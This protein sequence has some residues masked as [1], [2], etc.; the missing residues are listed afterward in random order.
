MVD[1]VGISDNIVKESRERTK[2]AMRNQGFDFPEGRVLVSLSPADLSKSGCFELPIALSVIS[3]TSPEKSSDERVLVLGGLKLSGETEF[4]DSAYAAVETAKTE[5]ISKVICPES[6]AEMIKDVDGISIGAADNLKDAVE[7]MQGR[8]PFVKNPEKKE[9][10]S[11][12]VKVT[13]P[14]KKAESLP[15]IKGLYKTARAI[16]VAVAGKHNLL[17]TGAP[18]CGKTMM[19]SELVPYLTPEITDEESKVTRRIRSVGG[20]DVP[21]KNR[22]IAPFRMPHQTSTIEG[23]YGGGRSLR[24]GEISL[25]NNGILFLDEAAE[26]R[27]SVLQMLRVPMENKFITLSRAGRSTVFPAKFQLMMAMNPC[28][29]GNFGCNGKTC[30]DSPNS[31]ETYWKKLGDELLSRVEIKD[32]LEKDIDDSR[33]FN[34]EESRK[35]IAAAY[36]IQRKRGIF[37][38]DLNDD[39]ISRY[40]GLDEKSKNFFVKTVKNSGLSARDSKNMLRTALTI[41]NMD[42]RENIRL[43]DLKEAYNMALPALEK[44]K[45]VSIGNTKRF[46]TERSR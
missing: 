8:K 6:T 14:E 31:R 42:S 10:L 11:E 12:D 13:F 25:A 19:I 34:L 15:F 22:N 20:R 29:C 2:A 32:F 44:N 17:L 30:L 45:A 28:P 21:G 38:H 36:K 9:D 5:G 39:E 40:C 33:V 35:R 16:E 7:I 23:M 41:A 46:E 37:N 43:C 26:F 27:T 1:I 3:N 18:G 24:P 4:A